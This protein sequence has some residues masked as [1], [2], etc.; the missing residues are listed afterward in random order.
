VLFGMV[1]RPSYKL[2]IL[3]GRASAVTLIAMM[4]DASDSSQMGPHGLEPV[5]LDLA[6]AALAWAEA[7]SQDR[8]NQPATAA[9]ADAPAVG[10]GGRS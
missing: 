5:L 2:N 9:P 7:I 10:D 3:Q 6:S 8:H 4:R 1:A